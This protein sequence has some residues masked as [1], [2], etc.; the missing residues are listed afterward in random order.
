MHPNGENRS[1]NTLNAY[2]STER[3]PYGIEHVRTPLDEGGV[4]PRLSSANQE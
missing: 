1:T 3:I 2:G 4:G